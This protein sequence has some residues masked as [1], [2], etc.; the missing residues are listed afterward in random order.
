MVLTD[1]PYFPPFKDRADGP[2]VKKI[3]IMSM[4]GGFG[5]IKAGEALLSYAQK[6]LKSVDTYHIDISD[7]DPS[8]KKYAGGMYSFLSK[9]VPLFWYLIYEYF[10]VRVVQYL[11]SLRGLITTKVTDYIGAH[12]PDAIIFTNAII[13]PLFLGRLKRQ[14]P[15]IKLGVVVTDYHGHPYYNFEGINHYFVASQDVF[16]DLVRNGISRKKITVTGIPIS[17][18]FYGN[19]KVSTLKKKY[20]IKNAFPTVLV[21]ASFKVSDQ[22]MVSLVQQ[23]AASKKRVNVIVIAAGNSHL[24]QLLTT[25]FSEQEGVFLVKWT[26]VM[27]EY[28]AVA[29]I[30]VTKAG[31]LTV[32]ECL[33]LR[34]KMVIINPIP[35]QEE[36]NAEFVKKNNLGKRVN[37]VDQIPEAVTK[38]LASKPA[39]P[40]IMV[41]QNPAKKIFTT[42]MR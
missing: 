1:K 12:D 22:Q 27:N 19:Q 35:G 28:M 13:L 25:H 26:N 14:F 21:V 34:K 2:G 36:R 3:I 20:G 37:H 30:V 42:I 39:G 9:T 15:E 8:L 41:R 24:Y 7:I 4:A 18:A 16:Q 5:H 38:L 11:V 6:K 33:A 32:S 10:P 17:P 23:L 40:S 31:G 29:D